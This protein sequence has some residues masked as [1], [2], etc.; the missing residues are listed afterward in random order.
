MKPREQECLL[1]LVPGADF[2]GLGAHSLAKS[3]KDTVS[4][5]GFTQDEWK[6]RNQARHVRVEA[7]MTSEEQCVL[8]CQQSLGLK[9]CFKLLVPQKVQL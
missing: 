6:R 2:A 7:S 8:V 1:A 5:L 3:D 9:D 4:V